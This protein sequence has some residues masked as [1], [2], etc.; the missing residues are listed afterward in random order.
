MIACTMS[1]GHLGGIAA[2]IASSTLP[3]PEKKT[4]DAASLPKRAPNVTKENNK[5][6]WLQDALLTD[7]EETVCFLGIYAPN[8]HKNMEA[9]H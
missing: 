8:L 3:I 5:A 1:S 9:Y 2:F 6:R 4:L 7:V